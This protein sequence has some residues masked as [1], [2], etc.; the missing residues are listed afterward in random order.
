M[1]QFMEQCQGVNLKSGNGYL[2]LVDCRNVRESV[3]LT[4]RE[5]V[6]A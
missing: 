4:V 6:N 1:K 2:L 3:A 5:V